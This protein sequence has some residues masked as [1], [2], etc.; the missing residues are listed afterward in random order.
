M[1]QKRNL[2]LDKNLLISLLEVL[3]PIIENKK[4]NKKDIIR[5]N[6]KLNEIYKVINKEQLI[7]KFI[8]I[9]GQETFDLLKVTTV[10]S[11]FETLPKV[12]KS[13]SIYINETGDY[14]YL[15]V[16]L[17]IITDWYLYKSICL[18]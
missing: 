7:T 15:V 16:Q 14:L 9:V 11:Y 1:E 12:L 8:Q 4:R 13:S 3:E 5:I 17:T 18:N 6:E 2:C 10:K